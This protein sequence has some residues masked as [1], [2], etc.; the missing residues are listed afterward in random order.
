[1]IYVCF[2]VQLLFCVF[3]FDN[4]LLLD[5]IVQIVVGIGLWICFFWLDLVQLLVSSVY[6]GN[7]FLVFFDDFEVVELICWWWFGKS[8]EIFIVLFKCY[9]LK[10]L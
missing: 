8:I 10:F 6:Y 7:D 1:M 4:M 5:V 3:M 2:V 9:G